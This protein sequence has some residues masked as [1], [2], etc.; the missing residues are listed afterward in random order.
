MAGLDQL[1]GVP[2]DPYRGRM[3]PRFLPGLQL[4]RLFY[5][6]AVRP[7][8]EQAFPGLRHAAA[9]VG[10]GS[11]VLGFDGERSVDHDW[12]PRLELFLPA[13]DVTGYGE[14]VSALLA[15]RLPRQILDWPPHFEPPGARVR[16]MRVTSGPVAHRVHITDVA[17]WSVGQLGF[18]AC[19]GMRDLD[20][21]AGPTRSSTRPVSLPRSLTVSTTPPSPRCPRSALSISSSTAPMCWSSRI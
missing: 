18:D 12:G 9:R 1:T 19:A 7:L 11:E 20:W 8:L 5:T 10:P 21:L 14:E 4:C 13:G 16:I 6:E 17:S 15:A 2:D 3:P